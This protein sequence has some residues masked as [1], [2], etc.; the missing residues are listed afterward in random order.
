M[1]VSKQEILRMEL[2]QL[3][4]HQEIADKVGVTR[5]S[6]SSLVSSNNE[7]KNYS[8]LNILKK[9]SKAYGRDLT[10][11]ASGDGKWN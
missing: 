7:G 1:R 5:A 9:I 6:V 10:W 3:G 4:T 11:L 8:S 2:K